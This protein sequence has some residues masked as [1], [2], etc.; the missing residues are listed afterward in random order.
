MNEILIH[1]K[2]LM[3]LKNIIVTEKSQ[4]QN[5]TYYMVPYIQM[6]RI[7]KSIQIESRLVV[8]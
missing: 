1:A 2:T 7:G 6:F 3:N 8:G 4:L 5:I